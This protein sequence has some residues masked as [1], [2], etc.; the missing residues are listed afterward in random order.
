[1]EQEDFIYFNSAA[2]YPYNLLSNLNYAPITISKEEISKDMLT[3]NSKLEKW[4]DMSTETDESWSFD[5]VEH[6]WQAL[7]ATRYDTFLQ[8]MTGRHLSKFDAEIF[9][10]FFPGQGQQKYN[11]W[12]KKNNNGI[13]P[14][15]ASNPKYGRA[16]GINTT[17]DYTR[18]CLNED[19]LRSVW[20]F[21]LRKKY[22]SNS[23]HLSTLVG[24]KGKLIE[25]ERRST[26]EKP[27]F[28]GGCVKSCDPEGK[29]CDPEGKSCDPE[30]KDGVLY[31]RNF[32]GEMMQV[33]RNKL[34]EY[35][36]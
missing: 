16:L 24:T 33:I 31:G 7:K 27:S 1:M 6:F 22:L 21:L 26:K 28:W 11:Y 32:M 13:I 20:T 34:S 10:V 9:D 2:K 17:M 35:E 15:L 25:F 23:I 3:I 4:F 14:K 8:F 5:T 29:S 18:E 30:G 12:S 36:N 19:L